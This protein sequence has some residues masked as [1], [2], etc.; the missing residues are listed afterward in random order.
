MIRHS[1]SIE[2]LKKLGLVAAPPSE[3]RRIPPMVKASSRIFLTH[4]S[5]KI[6]SVPW[7]ADKAFDVLNLLLSHPLTFTTIPMKVVQLSEYK[8]ISRDK[9]IAISRRS[10]LRRMI[11]NVM[12]PILALPKIKEDLGPAI[13]IILRQLEMTTTSPKQGN[14]P[15][16]HNI[17]EN[18]TRPVSKEC[19]KLIRTSSRSYLIHAKKWVQSLRRQW[20]KDS[21]LLSVKKKSLSYPNDEENS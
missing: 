9:E 17:I 14:H 7:E 12:F 11:R 10:R 15:M 19:S 1:S 18:L 3:S 16:S 2:N 20:S 4:P 6:L 21:M 5:I 8:N 13:R